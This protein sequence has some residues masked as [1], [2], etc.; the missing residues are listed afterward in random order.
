LADDPP[1][2]Q[3]RL[4]DL[5]TDTDAWRLVMSDP[6]YV[7]IDAVYGST[8]GPPE[9]PIQPGQT[10]TLTDPRTAQ[11]TE[12]TVAGVLSNGFAFYGI[13]GGDL[14]YPVL[15]SQPAVRTIFG[16]QALPT[17]LLLRLSPQAGP[18]E[19]AAA[20]QAEFL[21]NG[22][23]V[24]DVAQGVRD[25]FSATSQF[26]LLMQGYLGL[27]LLVGVT[28]LGVI[29]VRAVRE[30]R[31]TI[32]VLRALGFRARTVR[33]AFIIESGFVAFEGVVIGSVLGVATTWLFYQNSAAFAGVK[34]AYPIAWAAIGITI[35]AT[36]LVSLL[37]TIAPARRA[38][39]IKPAAALRIAD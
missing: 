7:L 38:A 6:S 23:V 21:R 30:R 29:M 9:E 20:L 15:M 3:V 27:G 35:G 4:P 34:V 13:G 37:A 22:M 10:L 39:V 24:T 17:S 33:R 1:A 28:G 8:G 26:F 25:S 19:V 18:A 2:L 12:L 16:D 31:R 11:S 5:A 14:R 32:A 36:L